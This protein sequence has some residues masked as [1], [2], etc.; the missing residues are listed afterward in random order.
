[1]RSDDATTREG[2]FPC[3]QCRA[4]MLPTYGF[5]DACREAITDGA[6]AGA[7]DATCGLCGREHL[8]N[9]ACVS[10]AEFASLRD[11]LAAEV[12]RLKGDVKAATDE[13][14]YWNTESV[15]LENAVATARAD[16]LRE[17]G[18]KM[19]ELPYLTSGLA[20]K[21]AFK[22]MLDGFGAPRGE[23]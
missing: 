15:R 20:M 12:E 3:L 16:A 13:M 14:M 17:V 7:T 1:M 21:N 11:T 8:L 6:I 10:W 5:C 9:T 18:E 19:D 23:T 22:R 2:V 4:V